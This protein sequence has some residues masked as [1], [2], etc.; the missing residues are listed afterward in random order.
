MLSSYTHNGSVAICKKFY[1]LF[2]Y[3]LSHVFKILVRNKYRT[4][5]FIKY[6]IETNKL[7]YNKKTHYLFK[8]LMKAL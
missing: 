2:L 6:K 7:R 5:K 4:K 1:R 3:I 8:K